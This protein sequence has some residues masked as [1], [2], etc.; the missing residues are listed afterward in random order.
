MKALVEL[1][2][3]QFKTT[4]AMMFQYRAM[5]LIW[6]IGQIL[7]PLVYLIV[8]SVVSVNSGGS[9][10]G[11][12]AADF[13]AYYILFMLVNQVSYTWIMY[14]FEYRIREGNFSSTLLRPVHPIHSDIADNVSS[15]LITLPIIIV[16]AVVL[17][18]A[19]YYFLRRTR[20]GYEIEVIGSNSRAAR[21]AG[22]NIKR[23]IMV[24]TL[25][26]GAFAGL[27]GMSEVSGVIH[28]LQEGISPGYGFSG[29]IVAALARYNPIGVLVVSLLFGALLVGGYTLQTVGISANIVQI[30]Q[31][32]VLV[33]VLI[34]DF[35]LNYRVRFVGTPAII[36]ALQRRLPRLTPGGGEKP[37]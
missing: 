30:L 5:L 19:L 1:Y 24:I 4:M 26:S 13:A 22:M 8:W 9:V 6:T 7:E 23:S 3:Q 25:L 31:G 11:F 18:V 16:V 35:L 2:L 32:A 10:G 14:E 15:K 12:T 36:S 37:Q 17:A 28:R 29:I 33:F 27:A 21:Y 20:W 34:S